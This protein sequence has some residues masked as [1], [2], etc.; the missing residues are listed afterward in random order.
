M[1][2]NSIL[3]FNNKDINNNL[4][5]PRMRESRGNHSKSCH[6]SDY[7]VEM[8]D[9]WVFYVSKFSPTNIYQHFYQHLFCCFPG[10][11]SSFILLS[12]PLHCHPPSFVIPANAGMTFMEMWI[13][14]QVWT[15]WK[16]YHAQVRTIFRLIFGA[17]PVHHLADNLVNI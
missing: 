2:K 10:H 16:R 15:E 17:V 14:K 1:D 11:I 7:K 13:D 9:M 4:S 5:F 6:K 12:F 8:T 3:E